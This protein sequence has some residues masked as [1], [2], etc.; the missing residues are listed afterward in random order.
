MA[1]VGIQS[2]GHKLIESVLAN[3]YLFHLCTK[4]A[5]RFSREKARLV[6]WRN[7]TSEA[8]CKRGAQCHDDVTA[9]Q[10]GGH[11]LSK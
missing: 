10:S 1:A 8:G 2:R 3:R 4:T 7:R 11:E 5:G 6:W 9:F